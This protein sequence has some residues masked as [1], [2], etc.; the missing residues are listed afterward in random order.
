MPLPSVTT[1]K[2]ALKLAIKLEDAQAELASLLGGASETPRGPS[3][4]K[5]TKR[6]MSPE[7]REKIAAAQK[8]RWAKQKKAAPKE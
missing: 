2:K 3:R 5:K 8:K 7:A 1:L 4:P 6:E